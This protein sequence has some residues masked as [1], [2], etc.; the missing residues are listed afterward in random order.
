MGAMNGKTSCPRPVRILGLIA[1]AALLGAAAAPA[2]GIEGSWR[3]T[4][5]TVHVKVSRCGDAYCGTVIWANATA[6][7]DAQ[8]GSGKPLVGSQL[9]SGLRR[10]DGANWRGRVYVP[11][12]NRHA[13]ARVTQVSSDKLRISGCVLAG[14]IC[15]T[16]HWHRID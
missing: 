16:R 13:S 8:K 3:N 6:R 15:Q 5:N 10:D 2:Q 4:R 7:A 9:L 14:L 11:D 12:I 1:G